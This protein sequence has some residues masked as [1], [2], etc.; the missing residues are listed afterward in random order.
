MSTIGGYFE[1][2]LNGG[3]E[4]HENAIGLNTGRNCIEY[5]LKAKQYKKI[6][7]PYYTCNVIFEPIK[8]LGLP[9][10]FY[11]IDEQLNPIF[12]RKILSKEAFLYTNYFGLK[13]KTIEQ[14]AEK[15]G[16]NLIVDNSQAFYSK[17]IKGID[18]FYSARKF[19][20]VADGAYLYTDANLDIN[21]QYDVSY[22]R[23]SHLLKRIDCSA[24]SA[25]EDYK[26][27]ENALINKPIMKMSKLTNS[28]L[29]SINYERVKDARRKN[30][31]FFEE[32]LGKINLFSLPFSEEIPMV[33]PFRTE[34][35]T[36]RFK[37]IENKIYVPTFWPNVFNWCN[38]NELEY[39][40]ASQII[41]LPID[42]RYDINN[43]IIIKG[44]IL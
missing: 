19:F 11:S 29:S 7:V 18:T 22:E 25:Y 27:N 42:Q 1:L 32:N 15:I 33:Y 30:Y 35:E 6:W 44:L 28:L 26:Q 41:P 43:L 12:N 38:K 9:Y 13:Q 24:E 34:N 23:M 36:L 5:L 8:K 20:G 39:S 21:L 10:E 2:E 16:K 4:Y 3:K 14:L 37:L 40:L 31:M 17:P